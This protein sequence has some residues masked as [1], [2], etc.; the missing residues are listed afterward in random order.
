[1]ILKLQLDIDWKYVRSVGVTPGDCLYKLGSECGWRLKDGSDKYYKNFRSLKHSD[2][3]LW[4]KLADNWFH[5]FGEWLL[6]STNQ[7]QTYN[8][9]T[10]SDSDDLDSEESDSAESESAEST[11]EKPARKKTKCA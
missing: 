7:N 11:D 6:E 8:Y 2:L 1:L 5:I 10:E 9:F 3:K 4:T